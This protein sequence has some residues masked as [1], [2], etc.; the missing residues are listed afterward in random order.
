M[1]EVKKIVEYLDKYKNQLDEL[2]NWRPKLDRL[3]TL[4]IIDE[5]KLKELQSEKCNFRVDEKLKDIISSELRKR[6]SPSEST[7]EFEDLALWIIRDWGGIYGGTDSDT[8]ELVNAF[9]KT[10]KPKFDRIASTSKVAAFMHPDKFIIYDSRVSY[11]VN[12]IILSQNVDFKFFPIP[13]GRNTKMCAFD[14]NV[15]I[16]LSH[17][18]K[19][20]HNKD[21]NSERDRNHIANIDKSLYVTKD[22]AYYEMNTL[23]AE[24]NRELWADYRKNEPF[25]TEMLLFS[26]ADTV[27]FDEITNNI[28]FKIN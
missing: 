10:E 7:K 6:Y 19:Y 11:T 25:Y 14:L 24:V 2:Y 22:N 13:E 8:M 5:Y 28:S 17:I 9:I 27:V 3:L 26:L 16:R 23:I 21:K 4:N 18:D 1:T 15:L 12:W 20:F